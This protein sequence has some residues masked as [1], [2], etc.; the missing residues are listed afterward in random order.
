[1]IEPC[2]RM[3]LIEAIYSECVGPARPTDL[4]G[5]FAIAEI[6]DEIAKTE[7]FDNGRI[8]AIDT[9]NNCHQE[10]LHCGGEHPARKYG[11]GKLYPVKHKTDPEEISEYER[12][13]VDAG[14]CEESLF[15]NSAEYQ[16]EESDENVHEDGYVIN[17]KYPSV[18]GISFLADLNVRTRIKVR[19]PVSARFQWQAEDSESYPV[20][21]KY[22]KIEL[23]STDGEVRHG[24]LRKQ[25]FEQEI[26]F[27]INSS[28]IERNGRVVRTLLDKNGCRFEFHIISRRISAINAKVLTA[29]IVNKSEDS[30]DNILYQTY[31][32]IEITDGTILPYPDFSESN[33]EKLDEEEKSLLL[34][35][36]NE[37][38]YAVGHSCS[39]GWKTSENGIELFT[40]MMPVEELPS[41]TADVFDEKSQ[42]VSFDMKSLAELPDDSDNEQWK[43]LENLL[44]QYENWI[45]SQE[46]IAGEMR[47]ELRIVANRNI[48]NCRKSFYRMK[49]GLELLKRDSDARM[50]FRLMNL[51]IL[52]Q[53]IAS[54][55]LRRWNA[56]AEK[57]NEK[58]LTAWEML[59][60]SCY[61]RQ[62]I[63]KW[64]AFQIAFI[65][66]I[67]EDLERTDSEFHDVVDLLWFPTG[68]GKTE[69][70][71][72]IM[73]YY[74]FLERFRMRYQEPPSLK[75]DG[76]NV[77]MR[78]TM[79]MLT[80]QQFQRAASLICAME[81]LRRNC[82]EI[83]V[84]EIP[85][86][87]FALGL[88]I[89][90]QG[91][92]NTVKQAIDLLQR[93]LN[94]NR[95]AAS[96]PMVIDECP[97]C[98]AEIG[99]YEKGKIKRFMGIDAMNALLYC[100]N[101]KCE[102]G[103]IEKDKGLPIEVIDEKIYATNPS[104][105][106]A[107]ADKFAIIPYKPE[108]ASI[109][110][111]NL[112]KSLREKTP[113][114]IIIQDEL[115]LISG[116][117]GSIYGM[118]EILVEKL[119]TMGMANK[120]FK[121]KIITS[122][123]TARN[124][125]EQILNIFGREK[126]SVFPPAACTIEDS[127]FASYARKTDGS[128]MPGRCY[129]GIHASGYSSLLTSEVRVFSTIL[130]AANLLP[131][132]RRDPWWTMIVF[133][134]SLRELGGGKTIFESDIN[135]RMRALQDCMAIDSNKMRTQLKVPEITS[136]RTQEEIIELMHQLSSEYKGNEGDVP[137]ACLVSSIMEVGI[138]IDRLSLMAVVGQP[139]LTSQYI[140]VTGRIGRKWKERPGLVLMIYNPFRGRDRS[141][142]E[143]FHHYHR[144]LYLGVEPTSATPF[145]ASA[146]KRILP[147]IA[148]AYARIKCRSDPSDYSAFE[149][150]IDEIAAAARERFDIIEKNTRYSI[151]NESQKVIDHT[152]EMLKR[153]WQTRP[154]KWE[155]YNPRSDEHYLMLWPGKY[156]TEN[157]KKNGVYVMSSMRYVDSEAVLEIPSWLSIE[158]N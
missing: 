96:S 118:Y 8:F 12:M 24:W 91:S 85:G 113:P 82:K 154:M 130:T 74:M 105:L 114:G 19:I 122:T 55:N 5:R 6:A 120:T 49:R 11:I 116:P 148:I 131:E 59:Q 38:C 4:P 90:R 57:R 40:D 10:I 111:Y 149:P 7:R 36:E 33:I 132:D 48:E 84:P 157:Q 76:T 147:G 153:K 73:A 102:F 97:W 144:R 81:F 156:Y 83:K 28:E 77:I 127:F 51:S 108:S 41:I 134:N 151:S 20:N 101:P 121:P 65:L 89:G 75:R 145:S 9:V 98:R 142:Y 26:V 44:V 39:A 25:F 61:D 3:Q 45:E 133:Y 141:H 1:M 143:Q 13:V 104:L 14:N 66:Q 117:L 46:R 109:F 155:E 125:S 115:H 64:R 37:K 124:S 16:D 86:N 107:T 63:G 70:Y 15:P 31:F 71:L 50:S 42:P 150:M 21:G 137:D 17:G 35:Y 152:I 103:K 60:C 135:S 95:Y 22:Q 87:R 110:G 34:L 136:R 56:L 47:P 146:I 126:S 32:S 112:E 140:Q 27:E 100:P 43:L 68:G 72:G 158:A 119:C 129:V 79:R 99:L 106:I 18:A 78:F 2:E 67:L 53:Q 52:L 93:I 58:H 30:L 69:A 123:A 23:H 128:P 54:K 138:D 80:T 139:K 92:P 88:W 62:A 29:A 94:N